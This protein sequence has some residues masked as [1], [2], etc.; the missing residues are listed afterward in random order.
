MNEKKKEE[1]EKRNSRAVVMNDLVKP[2]KLNQ[3]QAKNLG[4]FW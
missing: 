4:D 1:E 2:K 3:Q